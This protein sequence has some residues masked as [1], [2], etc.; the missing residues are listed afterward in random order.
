[1][2]IKRDKKQHM[3]DKGENIHHHHIYQRS[4]MYVKGHKTKV[5]VMR[6]IQQ[7]LH[8][9]SLKHSPPITSLAFPITTRLLSHNQ[10]YSFFL[11]RVTNCESLRGHHLNIILKEKSIIIF[12][13]WRLFGRIMLRSVGAST[14]NCG[15]S[16]GYTLA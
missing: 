7:K 8:Y 16:W 1:M 15:V 10:N 14:C 11:S 13:N 5:H 9:I 12:T 2:C 6:T 3:W 4:T